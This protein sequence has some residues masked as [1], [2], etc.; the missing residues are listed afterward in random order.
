M[1]C[2]IIR[3]NPGKISSISLKMSGKIKESFPEIVMAT[4][5]GRIQWG[6][7]GQCPPNG[8]ISCRKQQCYETSC[9]KKTIK[10][11]RCP[12]SPA[13]GSFLTSIVHPQEPLTLVSL[14]EGEVYERGLCMSTNLQ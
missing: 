3:E 10:G 6:A 9:M 5:S 1:S 14:V 7:G 8:I 11:I 4:M 2:K 13:L 12:Q